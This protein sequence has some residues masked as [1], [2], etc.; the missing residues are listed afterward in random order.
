MSASHGGI[1]GVVVDDDVAYAS[2]VLQDISIHLTHCLEPL[3][4]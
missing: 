3:E 4:Q 1:D 2:L